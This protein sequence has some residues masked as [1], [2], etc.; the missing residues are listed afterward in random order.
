M[1][2]LVIGFGSIGKRHATVLKK[3][4]CEVSLVTSQTTTEYP[5]FESIENAFQKNIFDYVVIANATHLHH[6]T[7]LN[8]IQQ[9]FT[10]IVLL[11]K[12]MFFKFESIPE[13]NFRKMI[14]GYNLRFCEPLSAAKEIIQHDKLISFS[15]NVGQ[16]LPTWRKEDYR[17]CY[18]AQK[19]L[20]GGSLRDLSHELD[21]SLWFCGDAQAVAAIGGKYSTL[22]ITSDDVY[23]ILMR[24]ENC[25]IVNLQMNYLDRMA[26]REIVIHT[27]QHSIHV[28]LIKG[29]LN[30]DGQ[31]KVFDKNFLA[32]SYIKQHQAVLSNHFSQF[33]NEQQGLKLIQLIENIE[34]SN[35]SHQW[36]MA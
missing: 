8:L 18:S 1:K 6:S 19:N 3:L 21:Y 13:N 31:A 24:C 34:H 23:S 10:G 7:L 15:A 29:T 16:Y 11:E 27:H 30:V 9:N 32:D 20:G 35:Q 25:P 17:Q 2:C 36:I 26:R 14:V 33:C 12:P 5:C 28:D 4:D 22:E